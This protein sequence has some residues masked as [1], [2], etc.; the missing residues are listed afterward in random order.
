MKT[1]KAPA[2]PDPVATAA[3]Q[4][5]TNK[6]TAIA[7]ARLN[8]VN[9]Y[10]PYG[11]LIY[12]EVG[13]S[14]DGT[15]RFEARTTLSPEQQQLLDIENR[16][17][18]ALSQL[19]EQQIGRINQSVASPYSYQGISPVFGEGDAALAQT[20]AEE[21]LLS[22]LNPRFQQDEE[23]LRTRLI[24]Q[25]IG[26][27]SEAYN[28]EMERFNQGKND[29]RMQAVLGGQQYGS[30]LLADS[31]QRRNQGIQEYDR[32]RNMPL[33]EYNAFMSGQQIQNPQFQNIGYQGAAPADYIGAVNNAYQGQLNNYNQRVASGNSMVSGLMGIGGSLAGGWAGSPAGSKAMSGLFSDERL[34]ENIVPVGQ[35][36]GHNVY[37]FNYKGDDKRFVGVMAQEVQETHPEA[38]KMT[39]SGYLAVNYDAIGVTFREVA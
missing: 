33:N 36:N 30:Q 6:E 16:S 22:R 38:V 13:T 1:P 39:D 27:N 18:I 31:L 35:E 3:A 24:N 25:G 4:T 21:A 7:N 2:P 37:E 19:G 11:S 34:K 15:P 8:N 20:K 5:A 28:R 23:A 17:G 10:T 12:N 32:T 9:Q 14:A 29:A 26:Q